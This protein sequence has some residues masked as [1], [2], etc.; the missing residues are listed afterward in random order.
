MSKVYDPWELGSGLGLD[1]ERVTITDMSFGADNTYAV[2]AML[3]MVTWTNEAGDSRIE[4]YSVGSGFD[5][6][7]AGARLVSDG[8]RDHKVNKQS[9][10]G[11]FLGKV[12]ELQAHSDIGDPM[13][14]K[15]WIGTRWDV[16]RHEYEY[17]IRGDTH[18][19]QIVL[20]E[21]YLGREGD[22]E[23]SEPKRRGRPPGSTNKPK[24]EPVAP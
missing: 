7:D 17:V 11:M 20:P 10:W 2:G 18:K 22:E 9:K 3:A 1:H 12:V 13:V 14:A 24:P 8:D 23:K 4:K 5:V 15:N 16:F 6:R 21:H 19:G